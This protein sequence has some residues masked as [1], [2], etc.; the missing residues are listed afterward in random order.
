MA[1]INWYQYEVLEVGWG[2]GYRTLLTLV[3]IPVL[4]SAV[5]HIVMQI[6]FD[7]IITT[8]LNVCHEDRV[9]KW[10]MRQSH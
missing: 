10:G 9:E 8:E 4:E 6:N 7:C 3:K 2:G 1:P 5:A